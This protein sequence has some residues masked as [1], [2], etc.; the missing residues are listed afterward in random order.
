MFYRK[1]VGPMERMTRILFG[2]GLAG[3]GLGLYGLSLSGWVAVATGVFT[4]A[5]GIVGFCPACAL[6]GRRV[7]E[8]RR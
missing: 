3:A 5:T 7:P 1:N 6:V 2:V 4:M 8:G